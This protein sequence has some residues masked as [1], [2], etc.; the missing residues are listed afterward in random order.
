MF[1]SRSILG[2]V[3]T[4]ALAGPGSAL[5]ESAIRFEGSVVKLGP[6]V[7]NLG[8]ADAAATVHFTIALRPQNPDAL[9]ALLARGE[10]LTPEQ[11]KRDVLPTQAQRAAVEAWLRANDLTVEKNLPEVLSVRASG[12]VAA[13]SRALGVHFSH[14][15][16]EGKQFVSADTAPSLP[17]SLAQTVASIN[18][19]QP[20]LH[21]FTN[22]IRST[23]KAFSGY[24]P[25]GIRAAYNVATLPQT[26]VGTT[27]AIIIDAYPLTTDLTTFWTDTGTAQSLSNIT[28]IPAALGTVPAPTGEETIDVEMSSSLAPASKVRVYATVTLAFTNID[29]GYEAIINDIVSGTSKITQVS[30]SLGACESSVSNSQKLTDEYYH[31]ILDSLGATVLI[32]TGD[33]GAKE[34]G[35]SGGLVPSFDSTSPYVTGVGGTTLVENSSGVVTSETGWTGSGGGLS[36]AFSTP[37]YQTSLKRKSRTVPDVAAVGDPNTGVA[38]I[39]NGA[40]TVYGGTSVATPIWA[41]LIARANQARIAN[42]KP[43]LGQLNPRIYPLLGTTSFRDILSGNNGGYNAV[44]G[45]DL[46]TGIGTPLMARLLPV[47][48]AQK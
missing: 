10:R 2:V 24:T 6:N 35:A 21:Y 1:L 33:S 41:G 40:V 45:Y 32:A 26:G 48:L 44:K 19:L 16:S 18:G 29:N 7:E 30:I 4:T 36:T 25:A 11:V 12:S 22:F 47:L 28:F 37:S 31:S 13:V 14:I 3:I 34:C 5:A 38:I 46:V 39:L 42:K 20:H 43:T 15:V 27:T 23:N 8:E 17:A 9:A